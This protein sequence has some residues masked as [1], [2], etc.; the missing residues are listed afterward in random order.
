MT[1]FINIEVLHLWG[2]IMIK[3]YN[4]IEVE[5]VGCTGDENGIIYLMAF[6]N[7]KVYVGQTSKNL[8]NRCSQH[9]QVGRNRGLISGAIKEFKSFKVSLLESNIKSDTVRYS[10]ESFYIKLFNANGD[11]GY[12]LESGGVKTTVNE[13]TKIKISQ[14]LK[15]KTTGRK[16]TEEQIQK[17]ADSHRGVKLSE[18]RRL[19]LLQSHFKKVK[20]IPDNIIFN[21]VTEANKYYNIGKLSDFYNGKIHRR[22]GQTFVLIND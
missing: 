4:G 20:S 7:G 11:D 18:E 22:S 21:S 17:M 9:C 16:M 12:N 3:T 15:G 1:H 19:K 8:C 5:F 14:S 10:F 13:N 2:I 6:P